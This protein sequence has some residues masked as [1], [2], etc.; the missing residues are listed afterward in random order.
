MIRYALL[1]LFVLK[2]LKAR[3]GKGYGKARRLLS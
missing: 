2:D 3:V 1:G